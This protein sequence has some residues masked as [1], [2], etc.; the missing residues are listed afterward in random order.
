M[1][2][3][4]SILIHGALLTFE[5]GDLQWIEKVSSVPSPPTSRAAPLTASTPPSQG[6]QV[7]SHAI[8]DRAN[9]VILDAYEDALLASQSADLRLRIEHAQIMVRLALKFS[10]TFASIY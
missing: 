7:N 8:G 3:L 10:A 6:F 5:L 1:T 9:S 2:D 4:L